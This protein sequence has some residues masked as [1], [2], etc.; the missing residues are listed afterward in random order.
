[1]LIAAWFLEPEEKETEN[2][3]ENVRRDLAAIRTLLERGA[4]RERS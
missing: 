3:L 1:M 2:E 4:H